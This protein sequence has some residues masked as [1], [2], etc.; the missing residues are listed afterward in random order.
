MF[1]GKDVDNAIC[2]YRF[3]GGVRCRGIIFMHRGKQAM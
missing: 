3:R 1:P 2:I